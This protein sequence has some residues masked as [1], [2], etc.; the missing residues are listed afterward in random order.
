MATPVRVFIASPG[1][2]LIERQHAV[3]VIQ[4]FNATVGDNFGIRLHALHWEQASPDLGDPQDLVNEIAESADLVVVIFRH[5]LGSPT[6]SQPSGTLEEFEEARRRWMDSGR[7]DVWVYFGTVDE[8]RRQDAG[9]QLT[10]VLAFRARF[11]RERLGLS[12]GYR[13]PE[14]FRYIFQRHLYQWVIQSILP[15]DTL[16]DTTGLGVLEI[17]TRV[18]QRSLTALSELRQFATRRDRAEALDQPLVVNAPESPVDVYAAGLSEV[19]QRFWTT[20]FLDS[21]Y[22]NRSFPNVLTANERMLERLGGKTDAV[23]RLFITRQAPDD[24][25]AWMVAELGYLRQHQRTREVERITRDFRYLRTA[26]KGLAER[27]FE[28]RVG[29]DSERAYDRM[30]D[31]LRPVDFSPYRWGL[32]IYDAFRVDVFQEGKFDIAGSVMCFTLAMKNFK[33]ILAESVRYF[34]ELWRGAVPFEEFA[35]QIDRLD[36]D[37]LMRDG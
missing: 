31:V 13:G 21:V 26:I 28:T 4:D 37:G 2:V 1:D 20:A 12:S 19:K 3:Q 33:P 23:R 24:E 22:W 14:E 25:A 32:S 10:K 27:G 36:K 18:T 9:P 17:L 6:R 16:K 29:W 7:P 8:D 5:R 34:E 11:E 15:R 30:K 35:G